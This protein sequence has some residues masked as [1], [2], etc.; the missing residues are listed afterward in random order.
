MVVLTVTENIFE[1]CCPRTITAVPWFNTARA[2]YFGGRTVDCDKTKNLAVHCKAYYMEVDRMQKHS[3][4]TSWQ[5][6][7]VDLLVSEQFPDDE[8]YRG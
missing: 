5:N 4:R 6:I 7:Q 8:D 2:E 3:A 1:R